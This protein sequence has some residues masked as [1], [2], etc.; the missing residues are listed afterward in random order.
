MTT[1][2]GTI[3]EFKSRDATSYDPVAPAYDTFIERYS[4]ALAA[5]PLAL[6][7][8]SASTRLL[9]VG[10]GT[11]I[12]ALK[13]A[14]MVAP[15]VKVIGV[16]LSDGMLGKAR[17]KALARG[18]A[19][20]VEFRAMDAEQLQFADATFDVVVSMFALHHFPDPARALAEM[21]RVLRPGGVLSIGVGSGP[22]R[23]T[24]DGVVDAVVQV[25]DLVK[26]RLGYLLRAPQFIDALVE[27]YIPVK[28]GN[29]LTALAAH[30]WKSPG[31]VPRLVRAAG[32]DDVRTHWQGERTVI[33]TPEEFWELQR[34][35]SSTA[36]KRL[37]TVD[38]DVTDAL[39]R[40]FMTQC[41]TVRAR[42][43]ELVYSHAALYVT[44]RKPATA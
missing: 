8:V 16:D 7:N 33:A 25:R 1:E 43:G 18:L 19:S 34:V 31:T 38:S 30:G 36:R 32:F 12:V 24:V 6:A 26:R 2:S 35:Y 44:A 11:G 37:P 40:E 14:A 3:D 28:V 20:K 22:N 39:Y 5:R 13:A 27:Q 15:D 29:E 17:E 23:F 9:D 41:R 10:T 4:G 42:G 21:Y